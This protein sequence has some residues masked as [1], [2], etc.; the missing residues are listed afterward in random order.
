MGQRI[1]QAEGEHSESRGR[2]CT[3]GSACLLPIHCLVCGGNRR[4]A[5]YVGALS[6]SECDWRD[7]LECMAVGRRG[8]VQGRCSKGT[9]KLVPAGQMEDFAALVSAERRVRRYR[10]HMG[11]SGVIPQFLVQTY[12]G[13][14]RSTIVPDESSSRVDDRWGRRRQ[15]AVLVVALGRHP[16][17]MADLV[18]SPV[19]EL[20]VVAASDGVA[21]DSELRCCCLRTSSSDRKHPNRTFRIVTS[22]E[23]CQQ[24]DSCT[25][26]SSRQLDGTAPAGYAHEDRRASIDLALAVAGGAAAERAAVGRAAGARV[27]VVGRQVVVRCSAAGTEKEVQQPPEGSLEGSWMRKPAW[28]RYCCSAGLGSQAASR[29]HSGR[30]RKSRISESA[31]CLLDVG[32]CTHHSATRRCEGATSSSDRV[33]TTPQGVRWQWSS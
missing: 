22:D 2:S 8:V 30:N 5:N 3:V 33:C 15:S 26:R 10:S 31:L 19:V 29:I 9:T 24:T 12:G 23:C 32:W 11:R 16:P 28:K 14:D 1:V 6:A 17:A 13:N 4:T 20:V 7:T 21:V 27:A 18:D 25:N